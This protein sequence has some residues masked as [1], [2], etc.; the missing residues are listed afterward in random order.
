MTKLAIASATWAEAD[1]MATG[2]TTIAATLQAGEVGSL[3]GVV[4]P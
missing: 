4:I 1:L 2:A 3:D